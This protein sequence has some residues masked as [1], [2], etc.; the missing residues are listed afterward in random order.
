M[1]TKIKKCDWVYQQTFE[2]SRTNQVRI[3][4][5]K[6]IP[7]WQ[8]FRCLFCGEYFS[9]KGAEEHFGQTRLKFNENA[10][11][12]LEIEVEDR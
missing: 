11:T 9:Q 1:I 8:S 7:V 6:R 2:A 3:R 10:E 5:G 4:N 12:D